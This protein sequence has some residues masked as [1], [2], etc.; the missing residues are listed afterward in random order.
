[1]TPLP[2]SLRKLSG[3]KTKVVVSES[4]TI[5]AKGHFFIMKLFPKS[6]RSANV[7]ET[8]LPHFFDCRQVVKEQIQSFIHCKKELF[9][10]V[11]KDVR[12]RK[13]LH[14]VFFLTVQYIIIQAILNRKSTKKFTVTDEKIFRVY[15]TFDR[16]K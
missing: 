16:K 4:E 8:L 5:T 2:S 6:E 9:V 14:T 7:T 10:F 1:M 11:L 12:D 15:K 3:G 13:I